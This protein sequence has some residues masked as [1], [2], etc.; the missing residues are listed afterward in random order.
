MKTKDEEK[1][2][3]RVQKDMAKVQAMN[4]KKREA[5]KK[6]LRILDDDIYHLGITCARATKERGRWTVVVSI[7][8]PD[9]QVVNYE[10]KKYFSFSE[11]LLSAVEASMASLVEPASKK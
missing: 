7:T 8:W 9:G 1:L 6:V 3:K 5:A 2:E 10:G 4:L 11:S